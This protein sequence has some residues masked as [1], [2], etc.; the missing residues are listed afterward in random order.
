VVETRIYQ[1]WHQSW[2]LVL[3]LGCL[4]IEWGIRRR[5]GLA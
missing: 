5:Y 4:S 2:V 3:A 1:L